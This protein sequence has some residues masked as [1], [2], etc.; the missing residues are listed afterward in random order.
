[1]LAVQLVMSIIVNIETNVSRCP[2][3]SSALFTKSTILSFIYDDLRIA[4]VVDKVFKSNVTLSI[5]PVS[6]SLLQ[7][8]SHFISFLQNPSSL[9][10]TLQIVNCYDNITFMRTIGE[11]LTN[12]TDKPLS[13]PLFGAIIKQTGYCNGSELLHYDHLLIHCLT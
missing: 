7:I 9:D 1:M 13:N 3:T 8:S 5:V 12:N 4:T 6:N 2:I 10:R 11:V